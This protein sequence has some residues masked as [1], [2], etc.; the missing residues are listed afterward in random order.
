MTARLPFGTLI[1]C[2]DYVAWSVAATLQ[3][4]VGQP[5]GQFTSAIQMF[6]VAST[7]RKTILSRAMAVPAAPGSHSLMERTCWGCP[8]NC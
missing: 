5:A 3:R 2:C 7:M 8:E 6:P 1:T 4:V